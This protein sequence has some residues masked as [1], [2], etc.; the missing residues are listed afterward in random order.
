MRALVDAAAAAAANDDDD[1]DDNDDDDD[2][3]KN[4]E[5]A[6]FKFGARAR[7]CHTSRSRCL[8]SGLR[9]AIFVVEGCGL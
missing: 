6:L 1:D 7:R 5:G 4:D 8:R 3:R 9:S 2:D